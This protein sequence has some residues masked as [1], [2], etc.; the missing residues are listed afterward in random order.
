MPMETI[1]IRDAREESDQCLV[2]GTQCLEFGRWSGRLISLV[3]SAALVMTIA[4]CA[5]PGPRALLKGVKLIEQ[6]KYSSAVAKLETATSILTT[7]AQAWNYLGLACHYAGKP[8]DAE[9]AYQRALALDHDL[10]EAHYNLGC[11]WLEQNRPDAAKTELTAYVLRRGNSLDALLKLGS[12]QFHSGDLNGAEKTFNDALHL[13][14]ENPDALNGLGLVRLQH[15]RAPEAAQFFARAVKQRPGYAPALLNLAIVHQQYLKDP[16]AALHE[17]RAYAALKPP[18]PD[19]QAVTAVARQL[20]EEINPPRVAPVESKNAK[21]TGVVAPIPS[22]TGR[23]TE[24]TLPAAS[25]KPQTNVVA[26]T[27]APTK[28]PLATNIVRTTTTTIP[29][30]TGKTEIVKVS[31]EPVFRPAQDPGSSDTSRPQVAN[32]TQ[33]I[34]DST[35]S[36]GANP[37]NRYKYLSPA[38][39][40][41]GDR[42]AAARASARGAAAAE[43]R[44]FADAESAFRSATQLDPSYFDAQFNL[45]SA[46]VQAG[47]LSVALGAYEHALAINPDAA[48]ARYYFGIALKQSNY[49]TDAAHELEKVLLQSPNETRAHFALG[50]LYANELNQPAKARE[51]YQ[52]VLDTDPHHP[53]ASKIL[54]WMNGNPP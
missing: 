20:D 52:K 17:Y 16:Q 54:Y 19:V 30:P 29:P 26:R 9:K 14:P 41:A 45:A 43:T 36:T 48:D 2:F 3:F 22:S 27:V 23:D 15:R 46:A 40:I 44:K 18:P 34:S 21:T 4:G 50:N 35:A 24:T 13:L 33:E 39:P 10:S 7:N 37:A 25:A 6:G 51:H 8:S 1:K 53:Q 49:P 31:P 11:L 32:T 47:H 12:A 5:P 28:S 42:A 38:K